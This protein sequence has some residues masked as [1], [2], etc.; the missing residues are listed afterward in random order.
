MYLEAEKH[1][2]N[3]IIGA[4]QNLFRIL[5]QKRVYYM[6]KNNHIPSPFFKKKNINTVYLKKSCD[7][8]LYLR[9]DLAVKINVSDQN[10]K[11][12]KLLVSSFF[13]CRVSHLF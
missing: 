13:F 7:V 10:S 12:Q 4:P 8:S 5:S 6:L 2:I 1:I 11:S 9:L 3:I